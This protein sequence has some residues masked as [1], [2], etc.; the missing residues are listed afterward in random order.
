MKIFDKGYRTETTFIFLLLGTR[1]FLVFFDIYPIVPYATNFL[2][3]F[4]LLA[5][6][7]KGIYLKHHLYFYSLVLECFLC[8]SVSIR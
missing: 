1:M 3:S 4:L 2:H 7:V 6:V 8:Y 5:T